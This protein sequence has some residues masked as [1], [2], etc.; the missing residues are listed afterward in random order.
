M[1]INVDNIIVAQFVLFTVLLDLL[2]A[3]VYKHVRTSPGPQITLT[4]ICWFVGHNFHFQTLRLLLSSAFSI[5]INDN[6]HVQLYLNPHWYYL[7]LN[8]A[9][10]QFHSLCCCSAAMMW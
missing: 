6:K 4:A 7:M 3:Y 2:A 9:H 10:N 5:T 8:K 1:Y